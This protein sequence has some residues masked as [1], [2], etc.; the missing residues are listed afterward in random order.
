MAFNANN[1]WD[2]LS[3]SENKHTEA[4]FKWAVTRDLQADVTVFQDR[5]SKRYVWSGFNANATGT[6][7]NNYPDYRINGLEVALKYKI[8]K[9]WAWF[10]GVT[11]LDPSIDNLPYAPNT[12]ISMGLNGQLAG[13]RI[14]L[15][16]Q[17]QSG[18]YTLTQDR[19]TYTP[20]HV[21]GFTVANTRIAYPIA[22]LGKQGE[23]YLAVNN[24]FNRQYE[25]NAG[26]TMPGRNVRVGLMV[27]F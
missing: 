25:Y 26:Y 23:I 6:W 22:A 14:G 24:I 13:L 10:T 19:G 8:N 3:P 12:A 20:S 18:M 7:S 11:T 5:I 17:R 16:A 27:S 4:G 15:D 2:R 9:D 21:N 1:G